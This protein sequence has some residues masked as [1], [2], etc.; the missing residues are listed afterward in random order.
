[1]IYNEFYEDCRNIHETHQD[2]CRQKFPEESISDFQNGVGP[3]GAQATGKWFHHKSLELKRPKKTWELH[4]LKLTAK[5]PEN[6]IPRRRHFIFQPVDFQ[7]LLLLVTGKGNDPESH[8]SKFQSR[9]CSPAPLNRVVSHFPHEG[10]GKKSA[11]LDTPLVPRQKWF[12]NPDFRFT[13]IHLTQPVGKKFLED[14][15]WME[16][17]GLSREIYIRCIL[18]NKSS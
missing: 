3:F 8:H 10:N 13:Q 2:L 11:A 9:I 1:M 6:R 7:V 15:F 12:R 5:A 17:L 18:R 4:S 16:F 14:L